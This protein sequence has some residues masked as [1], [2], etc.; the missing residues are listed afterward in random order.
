MKP[1]LI[2][3]DGPTGLIV[4]TTAVK[5]HPENETRMLSLTVTDTQKQTREVMAAL[6]E[7]VGGE[8]PDLK[9]WHALQRWLGAAEHHVNIPYARALAALIPPVA[10]RLRR[11]FG[12]LLNLIRA[13]AI[14]H[15][16]RRERDTERRIIATLEDY[17]EVR[18]L[19]ADLVSEGV[20]ATIAPTV[21]ETVA[22][23]QRLHDETEEAASLR[24][25]AEELKLDKSTTSR[26]VR[27]AIDKGFVKNLED[28]RGKPGRYVPGDPLPDDIEILPAPEVLHRCSV[29]GESEGVKTN[30]FSGRPEE[31]SEKEFPSYPSDNGATVQPE[32]EWGAI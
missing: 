18:S 19:V 14:L 20:E 17:A 22:T 25:I 10:V 32:N 23:V 24:A 1:R 30:S 26:R 5:L 31:E 2:E 6:A 27:N 16:A 28:R 9:A 15:Q 12:A 11:D 21:R 8:S 13:H 3:R 29:A 7:E 4:T